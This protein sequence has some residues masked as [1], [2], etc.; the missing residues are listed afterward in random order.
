MKNM[1]CMHRWHTFIV[2][3]CLPIPQRVSTLPSSSL[4]DVPRQAGH[5][6]PGAR[7]SLLGDLGAGAAAGS[8]SAEP[9]G[10]TAE[11][12]GGVITPS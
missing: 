3:L 8:G 5:T 7:H 10:G 11:S 12:S 6:R 1:T 4:K 9:H 2:R